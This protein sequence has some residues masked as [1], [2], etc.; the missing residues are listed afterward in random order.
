MTAVKQGME[1]V[2]EAHCATLLAHLASE[3]AWVWS[4]WN[5][6]ASVPIP[7]FTAATIFPYDIDVQFEYPAISVVAQRIEQTQD[8]APNWGEEVYGL[9]IL[10]YLVG[11]DKATVQ[12]QMM[13]TLQAVWR[14]YMANP[15]LDSSLAGYSGTSVGERMLSDVMGKKGTALLLQ[16]GGLSVKTVVADSY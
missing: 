14:V 10:V 11:D 4:A 5:D 15:N 9:H 13:R 1:A 6:A 8:A 7:V 3:L 16:V 2:A 12:K